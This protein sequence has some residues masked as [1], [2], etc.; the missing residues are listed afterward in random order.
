MAHVPPD[1]VAAQISRWSDS[2]SGAGTPSRFASRRG[3]P[4]RLDLDGLSGEEIDEA[5]RLVRSHLESALDV[6]L[7]E[8][9]INDMT[10]RRRDRDDLAHQ[11]AGAR[12]KGGIGEDLLRVDS[13]RGDGKA[14]ERDVPDQ[15]AP[16]GE[17]EIGEDAAVESGADKEIGDGRERL[18]MGEGAHLDAAV[19]EVVDQARLAAIDANEAESSKDGMT[20]KMAREKGLVAES[21]LEGEEDRAGLEERREQV[22]KGVIGGRLD[23]DDDEIDR[24]DLRGRGEGA[25]R[26]E[27][28]VAGDAVDDQSAFPHRR[29]VAPHEEGDLGDGGEAGAVIPAD[30]AGTDDGEG[31]GGIDHGD[32]SRTF[33]QPFRKETQSTNFNPGIRANSASFSV[34]NDQSRCRQVAAMR[35][36]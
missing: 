11:C 2:S 18:E 20:G 32:G 4:D 16:A 5:R 34:T 8:G 31:G 9:R 13:T 6:G 3:A 17:S 22:G 36:S 29:E 33:F 12:E 21:V 23:R 15:L 28:Q 25:H 19:G 27:V 35:R 26:I 10:Q 1:P 14:V 24:A 30:R 7:G